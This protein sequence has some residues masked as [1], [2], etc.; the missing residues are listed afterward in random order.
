MPVAIGLLPAGVGQSAS[1][2]FTVGLV[3]YNGT[4][5]RMNAGDC[6]IITNANPIL[7]GP[8]LDPPY[9][10]VSSSLLDS[11]LGLL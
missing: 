9:I 7:L 2:T 8:A 11:L 10:Y 6:W 1:V 5:T 4:A 3:G